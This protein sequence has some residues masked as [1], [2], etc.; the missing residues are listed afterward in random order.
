MLKNIFRFLAL[1][2]IIS[3]LI[4]G[5][6]KDSSTG[7]DGPEGPTNE[8]KLNQHF[9]STQYPCFIDIMF[10][11]TDMN[12]NGIDTLET[13]DFEVFE[14]DQAVSPTESAMN[15]REKE[16]IPYVLKTVLMLDNSSSATA[17]LEEI[18][19]AAISLV[20]DIWVQQQ[21]A[22]Y[23]FSDSPVLVQDFTNDVSTLT[24]AINSINIGYAST[25]FYGAIIEGVS[26]WEDNYSTDGIEQGFMVAFTD[27]SDTQGSSTL[28][29]ALQARGN[30]L[31]YTVGL[32]EEIDH[33][34]LSQLGNA[35]FSQLSD[36]SELEAKFAEIQQEIE[37]Y[38]NS[39]YWLNY[40]TPK[41]GNF[42]HTL[43]LQM[44]SND[45]D[46]ASSFILGE[47]NS[48]GFYSVNQGVYLNVGAE[49]PM[50][51]SEID[52]N[53]GNT[54]TLQ[55]VTYLGAEEA[56]YNWVNNY[57]ELIDLEVN[58]SDNSIAYVTANSESN[59]EAYVTV[60]DIA[61]NFTHTIQINLTNQ[62]P[63][64]AGLIAHYP[65]DSS[66]EDISGNDYHGTL[67]GNPQISDFLTIN[68][69]QDDAVSLPAE[70][71]NNLSDFT[72][73][74]KV[75]LNE[76]NPFI[77]TLIS[78]ANYEEDDEILVY[79]SSAYQCI[80]I[81]FGEDRYNFTGENTISDLDDHHLTITRT[82][83]LLKVYLDGILSESE[84]Q[85]DPEPLYIENN[86]LIVG[87]DQDSIGTGFQ[88]SQ[89]WN[90]QIDELRFYSR[91]LSADEVQAL[92]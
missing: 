52:L 50:G 26:R 13:A 16:D 56:L 91:A 21:F 44:K 47:F 71:M 28:Q 30:K 48:A 11:V 8:F 73:A 57:P 20:E 87:Q 7:P 12:G 78:G 69:V 79:Y 19:A 29:Q 15:I 86:G 90:G 60:E 6:G 24:S 83:N 66:A 67:I 45:N 38:A 27:G 84:L 34:V 75:K 5:C 17:N 77:N 74:A 89:T 70:V 10:Q 54:F 25:N 85:E 49:F 41:R 82:G 64:T 72:I 88:A 9:L 4:T 51:I 61:N 58:D 80:G 35:G 23:M 53:Y 18:K 92:Q 1:V 65:F 3:L 40:M 55:A 31:V 62:E 59:T 22:I 2:T 36:V 43:K 81:K 32:G 37:V 46:A 14:D 76:V 39:F 42:D 63:P 33:S 68:P